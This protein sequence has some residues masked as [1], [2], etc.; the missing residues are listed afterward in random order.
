M[1][2]IVMAD[3]N[4]PALYRQPLLVGNTMFMCGVRPCCLNRTS[5]S[6]IAIADRQ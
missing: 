2:E 4:K 5:S 3:Q 6:I 1:S